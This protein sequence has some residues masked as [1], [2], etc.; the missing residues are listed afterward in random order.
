[1]KNQKKNKPY[2]MTKE[3][4]ILKATRAYPAISESDF[5]DQSTFHQEVEK[6]DLR[7][8]G[9]L[10]ALEDS[11]MNNEQY[12]TIDVKGLDRLYANEKKLETLMNP[13]TFWNIWLAGK[14]VV[15]DLKGEETS[16][17]TFGEMMI[18]I[19]RKKYNV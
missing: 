19:I 3:E 1:M 14:Q 18:K 2:Y 13:M 11:F 9:Y 15:D 5:A 6:Q 16:C 10:K 7:R 8:E 4:L 17:K 12:Q